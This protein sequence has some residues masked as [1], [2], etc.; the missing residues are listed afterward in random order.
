[1][2]TIYC[3]ENK[4]NNKRYIGVTNKTKAQRAGKNGRE[5]ISHSQFFGEAIQKYGWE[6]FSYSILAQTEEEE[7]AS[8]LESAYIA[9]YDTTKP[10]NGYN[11]NK[12]GC[13]PT[14]KSVCQYNTKGEL[15]YKFLDIVTASKIT[16][17]VPSLIIENCSGKIK[18]AG[19][20]IWRYQKEEGNRLTEYDITPFSGERSVSQFDTNGN[21]IAIYN[22]AKEASEQTGAS[23]SKICMCCKHKRKTAG[24][25]HWEYT[26]GFGLKDLYCPKPSLI[27]SVGQYDLDGNLIACF[28]SQNEAHRITGF[29]ASM[30]G[31]CC[32]NIREVACGYVWKY[33]D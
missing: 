10:S 25:F 22:S 5:Y 27:K 4:I 2:W 7:T 26:E 8:M 1:M 28:Q 16:G 23:R 18:T 33:I 29:S 13:I 9:F 21:L 31:E 24:G 14:K 17:I 12:G 32:R 3:Y 11:K 30:I 19:G 6:N 15:I 20:Y